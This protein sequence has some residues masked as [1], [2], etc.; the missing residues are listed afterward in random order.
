MVSSCNTITL[1]GV[2]LLPV[3]APA[4]RFIFTKAAEIG[5]QHCALPNWTH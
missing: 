3:H 4:V 5:S 1:L 2:V